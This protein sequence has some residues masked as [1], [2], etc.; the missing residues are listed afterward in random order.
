MPQDLTVILCTKNII[1]SFVIQ[2]PDKN[3]ENP[4]YLK[5]YIPYLSVRVNHTIVIAESDFLGGV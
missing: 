5:R 4:I 3:I 2:K 1:E